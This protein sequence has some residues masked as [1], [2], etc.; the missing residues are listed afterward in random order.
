VV[1]G[2]YTINPLF[3]H[4]SFCIAHFTDCRG[5]VCPE[6]STLDPNT[7]QCSGGDSSQTK[8][9]NNNNINNN[10]NKWE[11]RERNDNQPSHGNNN[12]NDDNLLVHENSNLR[13]R[14][15]DFG[16]N[17]WDKDFG[18]G[19]QENWF[20]GGNDE[21]WWSGNSV[22][23]PEWSHLNEFGDNTGGGEQMY[24]NDGMNMFTSVL[25]PIIVFLCSYSTSL[26]PVR[27]HGVIST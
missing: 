27:G 15:K 20:S 14:S 16:N 6:K 19:H 26:L 1:C 5:K 12:I 21:E 11:E 17:D 7:C 13:Q 22:P 25:Q 24:T 4:S 3:P 23:D 2:H 9:S 10:N 18:N 8:D